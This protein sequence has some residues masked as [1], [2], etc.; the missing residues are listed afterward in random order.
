MLHECI[1]TVTHKVGGTDAKTTMQRLAHD[2]SRLVQL[3]GPDGVVTVTITAH[4]PTRRLL[5]ETSDATG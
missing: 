4:I 2:I 3:A 5:S 1:G